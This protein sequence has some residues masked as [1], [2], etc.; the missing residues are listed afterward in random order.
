[1]SSKRDGLAA[2]VVVPPSL[3]TEVDRAIRRVSLFLATEARVSAEE[4][5]RHTI[6]LSLTLAFFNLLPLPHLDGSAILSAFFASLLA[7][8]SGPSLEEGRGNVREGGKAEGEGLLGAVVGWSARG[9]GRRVAQ[10]GERVEKGLRRGTV[11]LLGV[12]VMAS[13]VDLWAG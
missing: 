4:R 8:S 3:V 12:V 11:G 5:R 6:S 10:R 2:E 9:W 1:M 13:V 7:A